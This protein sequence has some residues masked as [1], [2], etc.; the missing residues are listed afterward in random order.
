MAN[1]RTVLQPAQPEYS[2]NE[3]A[4][5]K[6]SASKGFIEPLKI[7]TVKYNPKFKENEYSFWR[8][9]HLNQDI[10]RKSHDR[11]PIT[12]LE[13]ELTTLCEAIDIQI[14]VLHRELTEMQVKLLENCPDGG[15]IQ[16]NPPRPVED[17][18]KVLPPQSRFGVRQVVYLKET[19]EVLGRLEAYRIDDVEWDNGIKEWL[20]KFYTRP[21]PRRN[22]TTGDRDDLRRAKTIIYPESQL[23]TI[24]EALPLAVHF[25]EI[26]IQRAE[27]RRQAYCGS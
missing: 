21:R 16:P 1:E 6:A 20:Y 4:Y 24:C 25:L 9:T 23:C 11:L 22:T 27:F 7:A 17:K 15:S 18:G 19:A 10:P 13:S 14:S 12:L 2:I 26:A 8:D 3:I 5:V